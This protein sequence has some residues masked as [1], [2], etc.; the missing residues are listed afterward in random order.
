MTRRRLC[1]PA[2]TDIWVNQQDAQPLFVV[3]APANDDLLA[4][5]RREILPEVRRLVGE[6]RVTLVLRSRGLESEVLPGVPRAGLRR[7]HLSQRALRGVAPR[8]PFGRSRRRSMGGRSRYELAERD[9][10]VLPGFRMREV[11]RL[12][13]NGHQTAIVTT[14]HDLAHRGGGLSH[15]RA[16]DPGEL[17]PLHAAALR[18]GCAGHLRG[19]ARRPRAHVPNPERKALAK[20]LAEAR[21]TLKALE[22]AYGHAARPNPEGQR[23]TM[24]GFKIAHGDLGQRIRAQAARSA[25]AAGAHWRRCPSACRS[26]RC[27][28]RPRSSSSPPRPST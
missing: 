6:R 18:P 24:R 22:Q 23:P 12:C 14:R 2:T 13:A 15:V 17:L 28:T 7:P 25:R 10:D 9:V 26:R 1:M 5:L 16:L 11:R 21:A 8:A 20:A 3:T 27:W 19:G 4:M